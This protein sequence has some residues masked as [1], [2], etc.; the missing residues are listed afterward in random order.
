VIVRSARP[1][2]HRW[3]I[4][5]VDDWWGR[6][7]ATALPRLFLDHFCATSLVAEHAG[8]P[9]AFLIGFMS[10]SQPDM[11]YIHLV[12]VDPDNRNRSLGRSLYERFF[13]LARA[14]GR[15]RAEAITT[16][17]NGDSIAF[18]RRMGFDVSEPI[19]GYSQPGV[20]HVRFHRFI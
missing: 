15:T 20:A 3:M 17:G 1:D 16:A 14:A 19:E 10:P 4:A 11:A 9:V 12:G 8:R 5:V 6:P 2:D 13:A 7:V 18:H